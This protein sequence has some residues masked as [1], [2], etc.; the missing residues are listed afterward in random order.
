[1]MAIDFPCRREGDGWKTA[2][3]LRLLGVDP[4]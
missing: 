1:L 2:R 4:T 3:E